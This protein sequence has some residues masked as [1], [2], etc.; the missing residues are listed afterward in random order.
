[1]GKD[2]EQRAYGYTIPNAS[3]N[4]TIKSLES[5]RNN[6]IEG[7]HPNIALQ[8]TKPYKTSNGMIRNWRL[9]IIAPCKTIEIMVWH[10]VITVAGSFS[11]N[12]STNTEKIASLLMVS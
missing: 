2:L 6:R 9:L 12:R 7:G 8:T 11:L 4:S 10:N 5:I 1:M 3:K